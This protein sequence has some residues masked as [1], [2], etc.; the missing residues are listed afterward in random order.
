MRQRR[1]PNE[2][3]VQCGTSVHDVVTIRVEHDLGPDWQ[4]RNEYDMV[5]TFTM[6]EGESM[7]L[8]E[9]RSSVPYVRVIGKA[10]AIL[11]ALALGT[12]EKSL[13]EICRRVRVNRSTAYRILGTLEQ[14]N[15]VSRGEERGYR[16]GIK[17]LEL[18]GAAQGALG[19]R[20]VALPHLNSLAERLE[21]SA[22]LSFRD[23]D[24]AVCVERVD[25]G[26]VQIAT[27][28][29]GMTLP[30]TAGGA[31]CI[32]LAAL[33]DPVPSLTAKTVTAP[34]VI[35][36][37]VRQIR[38]DGVVWSDEDVTATMGGFGCPILNA[39]GKVVAAL[40]VGT[41]AADL[42]G[43]KGQTIASATLHTA[44]L[45]SQDLGYSGP[46]PRLPLTPASPQS[47]RVEVEH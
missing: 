6:R 24:R 9:E 18:G 19:I 34:E 11:D 20:R 40:S 33:E 26:A 38:T 44:H 31:P 23:R 39:S 15:L 7:D 43:E 4:G 5:G 42:R 35:R 22:F 27:Y 41:L 37:R 25:R 13:A 2:M 10:V 28:R 30:L 3:S 8:D 45:I 32:L 47:V 36:E 14:H 16:L 12:E 29:V 1:D 17:L 21:V 46:W